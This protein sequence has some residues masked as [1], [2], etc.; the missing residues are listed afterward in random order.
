MITN[1][2]NTQIYEKT[3]DIVDDL[4]DIKGVKVH[5]DYEM[6][7]IKS[8]KDKSNIVPCVFHFIKIIEENAARI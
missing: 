8:I 6:A 7:L 2:F 1:S 4:L 5:I 3:F